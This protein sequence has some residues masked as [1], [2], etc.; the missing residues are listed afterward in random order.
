MGLQ[1]DV[2][3]IEHKLSHDVVRGGEDGGNGAPA[4]LAK[5]DN[6]LKRVLAPE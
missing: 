2:V 5:G 3:Y 1:L 6:I 4:I